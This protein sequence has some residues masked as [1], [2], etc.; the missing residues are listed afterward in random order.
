MTPRERAAWLV[1]Q[2]DLDTLEAHD[3]CVVD[4]AQL[5]RVL[6]TSRE[7]TWRARGERDQLRGDLDEA[8]CILADVVDFDGFSHD[9]PECPEDDTCQCPNAL[10]LNR[11]LTTERVE[12]ARSA[13]A[14]DEHVVEVEGK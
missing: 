10:R 3:L 14:A 1:G 2:D 8:T 12:A 4:R 11:F 13:L 9:D 7:Q 5:A 6:R